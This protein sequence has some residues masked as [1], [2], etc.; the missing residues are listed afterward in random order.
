MKKTIMVLLT[1]L[2][3]A[4]GIISCG[5]EEETAEPPVA[6]E[7]TVES[8]YL[9]E[10]DP[11]DGS[12]LVE[13]SYQTVTLPQA[14]AERYPQLAAVLEELRRETEDYAQ[15]WLK[16]CGEYALQYAEEMGEELFFAFTSSR[17]CFVQRADS[18]VLSI[19]FD[20]S[21]YTGGAH[22]NYGSAC[23]NYDSATGRELLLTDVVTDMDALRTAVAE[24]LRELEIN[25]PMDHVEET[26]ALFEAEDFVWSF[27]DSGI[28]VYFDPYVL[29]SFAAGQLTATIDA[30]EYPVLFRETYYFG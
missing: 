7:V 21:E 29:A 1:A 23:Y 18:T 8:G 15:M 22:S 19:R 24:K 13:V 27:S 17:E 9:S 28:T 2:L 14:E 10:E 26:L 4:V 25:E 11:A 16:E 6:M 12:T 30:A 5:A 20:C 3:L